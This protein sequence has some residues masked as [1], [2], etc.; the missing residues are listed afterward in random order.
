M[1]EDFRYTLN[2]YWLKRKLIFYEILKVFF[3]NKG[4]I[5]LILIFFQIFNCINLNYFIDSSEFYYKLYSEKLYGELTFEK[6]MYLEEEKQR[7]AVLETEQN[8]YLEEYNNG[9]ID[10]RELQYYLQRLEIN[11]DQIDGFNRSYEQ[12]F[13]LCNLKEKR[14]NVEYIYITPWKLLFDPEKLTNNLILY[15]IAFCVL[16]LI[17][18]P[19]GSIENSTGMEKIIQ[20]SVVGKKGIWKRKIAISIILSIIVSAITFLPN[21][22]KVIRVYGLE[23]LNAS[24]YS[25][26]SNSMFLDFI[27]MREYFIV[28]VGIR[29]MVVAM[30]SVGMFFISE[31]SQN[32]MISVL[33]GILIFLVPVLIL[34]LTL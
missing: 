22:I 18:S 23:G 1:S 24:V 12:Y 17:L 29:F 6:N 31:R 11:S 10:E 15:A 13:N 4:V 19:M 20:I 26:V 30:V 21:M 25:Y 33:V 9:M 28:R 34:I 27:T 2:S 16:I 14:H 5:L 8:K 32:R 3:V 7:F